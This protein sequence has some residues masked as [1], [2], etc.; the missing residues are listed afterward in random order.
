MFIK[1]LLF[2]KDN[3][4]H[5]YL[6]TGDMVKNFDAL[7]VVIRKI[8]GAELSSYPD[9]FLLKTPSFV[10]S[11]SE[12]I[13]EKQKTKSFDGGLRFFVVVTGSITDEAQNKL[14]KVLEEPIS[15]NHFFLLCESPEIL[16]PT[17]RSR[18]AHIEGERMGTSDLEPFAQKFIDSEVTTRIQMIDKFIKEEED[19]SEKLLRQKTKNVLDQIEILISKQILSLEGEGQIRTANF[20]TELIRIKGYLND[21]APSP[22]LILEYVAFIL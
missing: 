6:I 21:S 11:D 18:L 20:L 2:Q 8:I 5:A 22:R 7:Q 1:N 16:L 3:L 10:V 15:G 4:H 13:V 19:D 17:L 14:L 12:I 9:Y